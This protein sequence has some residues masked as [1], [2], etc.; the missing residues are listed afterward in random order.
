MKVETCVVSCESLT[1]TITNIHYNAVGIEC[2]APSCE[3]LFVCIL[4]AALRLEDKGDEKSKAND[5]QKWSE[6]KIASWV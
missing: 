4:P 3:Y 5:R 6:D 2:A 1:F